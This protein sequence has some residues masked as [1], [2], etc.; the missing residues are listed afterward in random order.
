MTRLSIRQALKFLSCA[1][2]KSRF[3]MG[4]RESFSGKRGLKGIT[5]H[6]PRS[7]YFLAAPIS[8]YCK[9]GLLLLAAC[10]HSLMGPFLFPPYFI[11]PSSHHLFLKSSCVFFGARIIAVNAERGNL[12]V[13]ILLC[14]PLLSCISFWG[15]CMYIC[16]GDFITIFIFYFFYSIGLVL[17]LI[18]KGSIVIILI[19]YFFSTQ[20]IFLRRGGG[21]G[22]LICNLLEFQ[23]SYLNSLL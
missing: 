16:T 19:F 20:N 14:N 21:G 1:V 7:P 9:L 12:L 5:Q 2:L 17:L 22:F 23:P 3:G 4:T 11:R 10:T 13:P 18:Q 15:H 6:L 8:A